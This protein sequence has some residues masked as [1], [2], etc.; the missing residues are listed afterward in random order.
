MLAIEGEK[1]LFVSAMMLIKKT[2]DPSDQA[3]FCLAI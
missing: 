1:S 2:P 3:L